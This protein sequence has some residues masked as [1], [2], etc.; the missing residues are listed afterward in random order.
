MALYLAGAPSGDDLHESS[1]AFLA[2]FL[3]CRL[4]L[5]GG[6]KGGA[7]PST[8]EGQMV[9]TSRGKA[10]LYAGFL[11]SLAIAVISSVPIIFPAS[12]TLSGSIVPE[13]PQA[14]PDRFETGVW[15]VPLIVTNAVVFGLAFL[16]FRGKI[17]GITIFFVRLFNFEISKKAAFVVLAVILG[18]YISLS[19][20]ELSTEEK[21]EDYEN[22]KK[23]LDA[24][25]PDSVS[26]GYEP[27]VTYALT[28]ASMRIF[29][30]Y[31]VFPFMASIL[32]VI[33]TYLF[34]VQLTQKRFAGVVSSVV[35]LQSNIF[36]SY[37][38]SVAYTNFWA[39]FYVASLY[40]ARRKWFL[41]PISFVLSIPAKAL[42]A[43]FAPMSVYY[44]LQTDTARSNKIIM[45]GAV[46]AVVIAAAILVSAAGLPAGDARGE[47][48]NTSEFWMGFSS[49]A[50]QLR[51]D[52]IVL[53]FLIPL[54]VL[55]FISSMR[56]VKHAN[57]IMV[58]IAGM[59]FIPP[60][61]TGFSTQTNQPYRFVPLVVFFA[62]GV[63]VLLSRIP[64]PREQKSK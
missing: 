48:F 17:P 50:N 64:T 3:C 39:L 52:G 13:I 15:S 11:F 28:V 40:L 21:W 33:L 26:Y 6:F 58:I 4:L 57:A 16:H 42:T 56:G 9:M 22:L 54:I 18:A 32:L 29:G 30:N 23:T 38:T 61:L 46:V 36:L 20:G 59:L 24:W 45:A 43:M 10:V 62:I 19:I 2:G 27:H 34:T 5:L 55:L 14:G 60:L 51:W 25:T 8:E 7:F 47:A 35:L 63:G 53:L 49:F 37:D 41:S 1:V 12:L 44:Y 31:A